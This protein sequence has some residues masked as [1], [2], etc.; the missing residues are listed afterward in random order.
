MGFAARLFQPGQQ[1]NG[2]DRAGGAG[3]ADD[4]ARDAQAPISG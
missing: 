2:I 1:A 4:D 3:D